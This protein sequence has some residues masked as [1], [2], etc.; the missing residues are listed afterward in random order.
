MPARTASSW[1]FWIWNLALMAGGDMVRSGGLNYSCTP[2]AA[3]G[4]RIGDV[5][6]ADGKAIE[7]DKTYR[8]AGWA[9]VDSKSAGPPI[10]EV[11]A[12]YLRDKK[13]VQVDRL[14]TPLLKG[15]AVNPGI[16][17]YAGIIQ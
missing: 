15:V 12:D 17:A 2:N 1:A 9:T 8:V 4:Q 5:Q 13:T 10:W 16:A 7:A 6:L 3:M 14:E 11:V